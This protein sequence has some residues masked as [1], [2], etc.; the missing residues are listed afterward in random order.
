M[1]SYYLIKKVASKN[2]VYL[3]HYLST[4]AAMLNRKIEER[5]AEWKNTL[6]HLPLIVKGCRQCGQY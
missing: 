2:F 5:L 3:L 6:G 1:K 4:G